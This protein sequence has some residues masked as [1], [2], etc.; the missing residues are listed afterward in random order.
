MP[1]TIQWPVSKLSVLLCQ[2]HLCCSR[3]TY[4]WQN[5]LMKEIRLV[6]LVHQFGRMVLVWNG[7]SV[8]LSG[9]E[10]LS[11]NLSDRRHYVWFCFMICVELH[12]LMHTKGQNHREGSVK[13]F[14]PFGYGC[15]MEPFF[16]NF[17]KWNVW[18]RSDLSL[19]FQ[20]SNNTNK[21][22][23]WGCFEPV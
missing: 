21:G 17:I 11:A 10:K 7:F 23:L 5:V 2:W 22:W 3:T 1:S 12:M 4:P 15:H 9:W 8:E 20:P 19:F 14:C 18:S 16:S 6:S 13:V